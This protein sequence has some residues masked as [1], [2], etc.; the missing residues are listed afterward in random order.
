[1]S[2]N[3][4]RKPRHREGRRGL[5]GAGR[6]G[7]GTVEA[8]SPALS[9]CWVSAGR[10]THRSP[11]Q[12]PLT[13]PFLPGSGHVAGHAWPLAS[14]PAGKHWVRPFLLGTGCLEASFREVGKVGPS[15]LPPA[16]ATLCRGRACGTQT[17]LG[18]R[19]TFH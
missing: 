19:V 11:A 6:Q 15:P 9:T 12:G 7:K 14:V 5:P 3:Q 4:M 2:M 17:I 1:M 13:T 8:T 16:W 18:L 10:Q